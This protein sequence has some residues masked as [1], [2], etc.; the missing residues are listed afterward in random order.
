MSSGLY[1]YCLSEPLG[2]PRPLKAGAVDGKGQVLVRS[3]AGISA[4]VSDLSL[5]D[6]GDMQKKARDDVLWIKQKALAHEKVVEEAMGGPANNPAPV[7]PMKFGVVFNTGQRLAETLCRQGKS[8]RAAFDRV[9]GKQEWSVKLFLKNAQQFKQQVREQ[10]GGLRQKTTRLAALPA[11]MAYFMEQELEE[12]LQN[13]CSRRWDQEARRA[14]EQLTPL[15]AEAARV[16]LL[17]GKLTGRGEPMVLN[18]AFLVAS[19]RLP[20][21]ADAV[22]KLRAR[23][24]RKGFL[25]EQ[26]GP[27][28]PYN[29][30]EFAHVR[31]R[32]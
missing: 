30:T 14:Y 31:D 8:I 28:P 22:D 12:E 9:R 10:S 2:P 27:W 11:G 23:L 18:S 29:F 1:L 26:G 24:G 13:E 15:A 3:V 25:L 21:F 32:Q 16:K 20:A 7:I 6:F 4:V 5:D 19:D 17:D